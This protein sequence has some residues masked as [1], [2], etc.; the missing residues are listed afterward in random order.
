MVPMD[1]RDRRECWRG[2]RQVKRLEH[3]QRGVEC[4]E[5]APQAF[6]ETSLPSTCA[7]DSNL[8]VYGHAIYIKAQ[9]LVP[10]RCTCGLGN[11]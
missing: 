11:I 3:G 6:L 5:G 4:V 9:L 8:P 10:M 1:S 2:D 7:S